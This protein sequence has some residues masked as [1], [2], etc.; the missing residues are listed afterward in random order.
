MQYKKFGDQVYLRGLATS[1]VSSWATYPTIF[2]LPTGSR[3]PNRLV[4]T[5]TGNIDVAIRVDIN[6]NGTVQWF[7][8]GSGTGYVSLDGISFSTLS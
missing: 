5:Q 4:F 6:S 7:A 2:T 8:G 1:G 3:P